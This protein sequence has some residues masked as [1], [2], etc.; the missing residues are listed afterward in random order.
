MLIISPTNILFSL[1]K[2]KAKQ[3]VSQKSLVSHDFSPFNFSDGQEEKVA[4]KIE[5]Q[6]IKAEKIESSEAK[7][8]TENEVNKSKTNSE[9]PFNDIADN[10]E[11]NEKSKEINGGKITQDEGADTSPN[12]VNGCDSN[13]NGEVKEHSQEESE[14]KKESGK[15]VCLFVSVRSTY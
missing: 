11:K 8:S 3:K 10:N 2:V 5:T 4:P 13:T 1:N 9:D 12:S 15:F 14:K 7:K 6:T